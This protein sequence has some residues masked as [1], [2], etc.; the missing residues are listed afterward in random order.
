MTEKA[1]LVSVIIV[2]WNGKGVIG[3]CLDALRRQTF[4]DFEII[5]VDN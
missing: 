1:P 4:K 5:V 2:N 3:E